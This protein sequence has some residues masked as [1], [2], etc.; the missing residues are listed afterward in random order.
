MNVEFLNN[1]IGELRIRLAGCAAAAHLCRVGIFS[2]FAPP[3]R[4][5]FPGTATKRNQ[6]ACKKNAIP[7]SRSRSAFSDTPRQK[8]LWERTL[9]QGQAGVRA[10]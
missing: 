8:P 5:I 2:L 9:G 3:V 4:L 6:S 10:S 1:C 7:E